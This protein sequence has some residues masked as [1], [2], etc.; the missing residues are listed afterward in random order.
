MGIPK[1]SNVEGYTKPAACTATMLVT[2]FE[3]SRWSGCARICVTVPAV[4]ASAKHRGSGT[5]TVYN[6]ADAPTASRTA[7]G[8]VQSIAL[9]T[10][11]QMGLGSSQQATV[12]ATYVGGAVAPVTMN[13]TYFSSATNILSVPSLKG[14]SKEKCGH[15]SQKPLDLIAKL[16]SC[17]SDPG[18]LVLDPFLG[19]G[20]TVV[21]AESLGRRWLGI[22]VNPIF[23]ELAR[24]R[25]ASARDLL[26]PAKVEAVPR[27]RAI[28]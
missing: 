25:L 28:A 7:H 8:V 13:S 6:L 4:T 2:A 11:P 17:A 20:T 27:S 21:V 1:P 10:S 5:N 26:T 16:V 22:E 19:S 24:Q 18:D 23:V 3:S 12:Q 15:P 14:S 9:T